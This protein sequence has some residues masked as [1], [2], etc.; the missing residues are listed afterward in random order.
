MDRTDIRILTYLKENARISASVIGEKINM[1]VSAVIERIRKLEDAGIIKQYTLV[2]DSKLIDK[3]VS[4][5]ISVSL[6]HPK[7]SKGFT[8]SVLGN[9]QIVECHYITGDFDY[10]LKAVINSTDSL[11]RVLN[12]IKSIP[13][14][15]VTKTLVVLSTIK[16]DFTVLPDD[17]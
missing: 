10:L 4:A 8:A 6:E 1:S 14:V 16:N 5:F 7:Y 9:K 17:K 12:D 13:G 11:E 15:S 3:D 2:L